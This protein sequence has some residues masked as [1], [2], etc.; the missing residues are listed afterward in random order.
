M[1]QKRYGKM[2]AVCLSG[3]PYIAIVELGC[4]INVIKAQD[5]YNYD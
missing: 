4:S 2:Y 1:A 5:Y 3:A